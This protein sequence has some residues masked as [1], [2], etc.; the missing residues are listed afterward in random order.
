MQ[1][2]KNILS[3]PAQKLRRLGWERATESWLGQQRL[4]S[5][6][7]VALKRKG[8]SS[9]KRNDVTHLQAEV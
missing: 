2:D 4:D 9:G 5:P 6:L 3:Q 8:I 7:G 1:Q